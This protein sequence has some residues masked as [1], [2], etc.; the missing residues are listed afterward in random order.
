MKCVGFRVL[1]LR[2]CE[3]VATGACVTRIPADFPTAEKTSVAADEVA[4]PA[5]FEL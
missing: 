1:L 4:P 5:P 3:W 2:S